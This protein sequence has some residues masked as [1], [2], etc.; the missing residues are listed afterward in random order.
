MSLKYYLVGLFLLSYFSYSQIYF[1]PSQGKWEQK[2]PQSFNIDEAGLAKA[3]NFA[4]Q[5]EYTGEKDLR[6]AILKAFEREP[7]HE[8]LGPTK[9]EGGQQGLF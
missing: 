4:K 3:V 6:I 2:S 7:F 1:P 9:K 5:N 8:I